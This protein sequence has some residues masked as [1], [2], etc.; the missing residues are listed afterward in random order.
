MSDVEIP[1]GQ[2][3]L[4]STV[5]SGAAETPI[6]W[7]TIDL[8]TPESTTNPNS[9]VWSATPLGSGVY[10]VSLT[11][12]GL[13]RDSI[14]EGPAAYW[15]ILDKDGAAVDITLRRHTVRMRMTIVAATAGSSMLAMFGVKSRPGTPSVGLVR[16]SGL[17]TSTVAVEGCGVT[18]LSSNST[19]AA[20]G[21]ARVELLLPPIASS[22]ATWDCGQ[23]L[24]NR[25]DSSGVRINGTELTSDTDATPGTPMWAL[26]LGSDALGVTTAKTVDLKIEVLVVETEP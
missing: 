2:V 7:R 19:Q 12:D 3:D 8:S 20:P 24:V 16:A 9:M 25:F 1:G 15:T 26:V 6:A 21:L 11:G 18:S 5:E 22:S 17:T 13:I 10:R 14:S 23:G 4:P